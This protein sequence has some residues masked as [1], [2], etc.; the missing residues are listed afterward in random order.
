M[1]SSRPG[2]VSVAIKVR[3]FDVEFG[4][5]A[6]SSVI[7]STSALVIAENVD[8]TSSSILGS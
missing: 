6:M 7:S 2:S 3:S 1:T 4:S 8:A 5:V